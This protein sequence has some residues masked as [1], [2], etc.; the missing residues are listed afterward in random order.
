VAV[1]ALRALHVYFPDP[2]WKKRHHKRRLFSDAFVAECPRV[3]GDGG[4]LH[5]ATDV[6][7]YAALMGEMLAGQPLLRPLPPPEPAAPGHDLDYLTH[8]ERKFR[9][10]GR[11]I[12]R[13]LYER[14]EEPWPSGVAAS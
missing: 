6:A 3:L 11:P 5:I 1:A 14:T 12:H 2:W 13:L 10:E 9:K 7:D 4:R 8:F